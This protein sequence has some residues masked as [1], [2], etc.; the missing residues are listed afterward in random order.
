MRTLLRQLLNSTLGSGE[1]DAQLPRR[2]AERRDPDA[3]GQLVRRYGGLVWGQCRHLLANEA[4]A[5]DAFQATFLVLAR[6]A[7]SVRAADRLGPWL[8]GVAYR[9][10]RNARRQAARR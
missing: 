8:H 4:D 1:A 6:A 3:F 9:V 2:F 7:R 5:D 10:C